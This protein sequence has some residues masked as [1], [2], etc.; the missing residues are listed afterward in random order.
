MSRFIPSA[1]CSIV[2]MLAATL[3]CELNVLG[4]PQLPIE[5]GTV[6]NGFQDDFDGADLQANWRS[7]RDWTPLP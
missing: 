7:L 1:I 2:V 6:V 5:V 3:C 4:Q